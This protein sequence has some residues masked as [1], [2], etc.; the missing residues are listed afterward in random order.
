MGVEEN[1]PAGK[2]PGTPYSSIWHY[3]GNAAVAALWFYLT[4]RNVRHILGTHAFFSWDVLVNDALLL[5]NGSLTVLFLLRR[6]AKEVSRRAKEWLIAGAG[7]LLG[8]FYL[9]EGARPL[10]PAY[11]H[12]AVYFLMVLALLL[13]IMAI[14]SLGWSFGIVPANRGIKNKGLYSL[15]RHPIYSFYILFDLTLIGMMFSWLNLAVLYAFVITC[16]LRAVYEERLLR[17]DAAYREYAKK[18]RYMFIPGIF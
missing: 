17:E 13:G 18:T 14:I 2:L 7:T 12:G 15:V 10:F 3:L 9:T 8:G 11:M 1:R 5:R 6:P 16:Y 4:A